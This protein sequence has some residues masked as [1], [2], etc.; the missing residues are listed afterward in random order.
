[1]G[2]FCQLVLYSVHLKHL[3]ACTRPTTVPSITSGLYSWK[4]LPPFYGGVNS[5][6][7][8]VVMFYIQGSKVLILTI[9]TTLYN[10]WTYE[11]TNKPTSK[12]GALVDKDNVQQKS[13]PTSTSSWHSYR[14]GCD[15][16]TLADHIIRYQPS[17]DV[18][19]KKSKASRAA[20]QAIENANFIIWSEVAVW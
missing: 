16:G 7:V 20:E 18:L 17:L 9:S 15:K 3:S 12:W 2:W 13:S 1:M 11:S 6:L 19:N 4:F 10:I 14:L 5:K 8:S